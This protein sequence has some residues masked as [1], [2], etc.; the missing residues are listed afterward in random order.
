ME[1]WR[2]FDAEFSGG[3]KTFVLCI[4]KSAKEIWLN[5]IRFFLLEVACKVWVNVTALQHHSWWLQGKRVIKANYYKSPPPSNVSYKVNRRI[6]QW[7]NRFLCANSLFTFTVSVMIQTRSLISLPIQ[8]NHL[9]SWKH[10]DSSRLNTSLVIDIMKL[11]TLYQLWHALFT[12]NFL[13]WGT[14]NYY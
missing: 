13:C 9:D 2:E 7:L 10:S 1:S 11:M 3:I 6:L 4:V 5:G 8:H 14:S 12:R